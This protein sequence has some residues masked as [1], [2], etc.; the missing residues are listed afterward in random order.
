MAIID[1]VSKKRP[2][3]EEKKK[4]T[5]KEIYLLK[6]LLNILLYVGMDKKEFGEL[7]FTSAED[8]KPFSNKIPI[9]MG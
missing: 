7:L 8:T 9:F 2:D 5:D 4:Y 1:Y 3:V 6:A